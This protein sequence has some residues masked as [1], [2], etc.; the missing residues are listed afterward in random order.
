MSNKIASLNS[1]RL[2]DNK[3]AIIL[4]D[5]NESL[6]DDNIVEREVLLAKFSETINKFY[7]TLNSPLFSAN[8]FAIGTFPNH[9][10]MNE[11]FLEAEQD[12]KV[13]Y[14]EINSLEGFISSNFNTLQTQASALRGRL[15][16]VSSDFG[17]FK[18]QATDNL[19]GGTY[20]CDSFQ[21]VEKISYESKLYDEAVCSIDIQSG[22]MTLPINISKT[23]TYSINE[24]TVGSGSNGQI[25]NNQ[26]IGSL[27]RGELKSIIDDKADTWFEYESVSTAQSDV[28]L[29]LELK[30][31]LEKES[32]IN[33]VSITSTSFSTRNYPRIT[34]LELSIDGKEFSDVIDEVPSSV[35][36]GDTKDKVV[37]LDPSSGKFS[38]ITKIKI[39]PSKAKYINIVFQ[40]DDAHIIKSSGGIK[41]RKVIGIRGVEPVGEVYEAIGEIAS[42]N[43]ASEDEIKKLSVISNKQV[44]P[45]LTEIRHLVSTDDGQN[46]NE[47]QSIEKIG[48]DIKEILNFNIEGI[49][50]I[51]TSSPV[52]SLRHKAILERVSNGF[53]TRGGTEKT[54]ESKSEFSRITG[55]T[56]ELS[57][58]ERPIS[59]TL[60]IKNISFG[61]VGREE[62]HLVN[63]SDI[64]KRDGFMFVYLS[65][66]PFLS[67]SIIA[68]QEIIK[69]GNETWARTSDL[70]GEGAGAKV[71]E[72]DYLNNIITFGDNLTGAQP[73][74]DIFIGLERERVEIGSDSPRIVKTSFDTDGVLDTVSVYRIEDQKT[75]VA[76]ILP[77]G[78]SIL[79]TNLTDLVSITIVSD[80]AGALVVEKPFVNGALELS[81]AGDYSIDYTKGII[82]TFLLTSQSSD[83]TIDIAYTPRIVVENTSISDGKIQIPEEDYI[84]RTENKTIAIAS[85]T[86]VTSIGSDFIE[87]RSIRFL[88]LSGNFKTEVA[89]IGDG[90][91][92][93]LG[94]SPTDLA[95]H[96][97]IDYRNGVIYTY[98]S[99]SGS[100]VIEY[101][102]TFYF[103][104]YNIAVEV[105]RDDYT[106]NEEEN[107]ITFTNKYVIKNFSDS[108][109]KNFLRTLFKIDYDF[110]TELEQNPRELEPYFTPLLKDY[111]L[112][113]ITKGQL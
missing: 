87:P 101:N 109:S 15:R 12:L 22:A 108:L 11:M 29:I 4:E 88:S 51:T 37:I 3:L 39:P 33:T 7:R 16:K 10:K 26:E 20:F 56:Q 62:Y 2:L 52:V 42:I 96:Y 94:L 68:D 99:I 54:R 63:S 112:A 74:L 78:G 100:L 103:A 97:S 81:I 5:L 13:I 19:G 80:L 71:Y 69:I 57:T 49:E 70:S 77:K 104:E 41:Y 45:G 105:P 36:F 79:R 25:G 91:E 43:F 85:A 67:E 86:N 27:L 30:L 75:K 1:S 84:T 111:A 21:N 46:W 40:Q 34:K 32:I 73:D 89:F 61:S 38:G 83:T 55:G 53:S 93:D 59:S 50:S 47:I 58:I 14:R 65:N 66:P 95:G 113:T 18:L 44:T 35:L 92:F 6:K 110:V 72:F 64:I 98:D 76:H 102:R 60:S 48:R 107:K 24:I 23:E 17:D 28:P 90:S 31:I 82:Y 106:I 8:S 9:K